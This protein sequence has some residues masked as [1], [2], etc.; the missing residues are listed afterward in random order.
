MNHRLIILI[1]IILGYGVTCLLTAQQIRVHSSTLQWATWSLMYY[2]FAIPIGG[3][4]GRFF[5]GPLIILIMQNL[6]FC[7]VG[8]LVWWLSQ[9]TVSVLLQSSYC[10]LLCTLHYCIVIDFHRALSSH[11]LQY[12]DKLIPVAM[13]TPCLIVIGHVG[14]MMTGGWGDRLHLILLILLGC[15]FYSAIK[16]SFCNNFHRSLHG[17]IILIQS[18]YQNYRNMRQNRYERWRRRKIHRMCNR[19]SLQYSIPLILVNEIYHDAIFDSKLL[20]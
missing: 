18:Q 6:T 3:M 10:L 9:F 17:V 7:G 4:I 20:G 16:L 1:L 12:L 14:Q 8:L 13:C 5:H 2:S 15:P 11:T 19:L